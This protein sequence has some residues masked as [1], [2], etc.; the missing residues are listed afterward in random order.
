[1]KLLESKEKKITEDKNEKNAP[2][3]DITEA[4]LV[5]CN[6]VNDNYQKDS[7]VLYTFVP[8]EP[9]GSLLKISPKTHIFVKTFNS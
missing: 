9:F 5:H 1:M 8:N 7:I 3:S 2:H 6:I 4:V